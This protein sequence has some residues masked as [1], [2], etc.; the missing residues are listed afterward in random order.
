MVEG[1]LIFLR[2]F[3]KSVISQDI[4]DFLFLTIPEDLKSKSTIIF[5]F[6]K[7]SE[8]TTSLKNLFILFFILFNVGW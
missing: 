5:S 8:G 2:F 6:L 3:W 4:K 1:L 7:L